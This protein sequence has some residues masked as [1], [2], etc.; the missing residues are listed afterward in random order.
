MLRCIVLLFQ[1]ISV[2]GLRMP[3]RRAVSPD[4]TRVDLDSARK[5]HAVQLTDKKAVM[6]TA[7]FELNGEPPWILAVQIFGSTRVLLPL[8]TSRTQKRG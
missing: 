2:S 8:E 6:Y 1:W 7:T 5:G 4:S 3:I